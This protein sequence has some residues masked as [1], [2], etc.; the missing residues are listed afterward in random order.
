MEDSG[1]EH[2]LWVLMRVAIWV[3]SA[4]VR[5]LGPSFRALVRAIGVRIFMG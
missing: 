5:R 4:V 3:I 2:L 1:V